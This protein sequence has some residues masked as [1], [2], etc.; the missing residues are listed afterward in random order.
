[1]LIDEGKADQFELVAF[2]RFV[3]GQ[4]GAALVIGPQIVAVDEG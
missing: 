3:D 4:G 1:V 2:D